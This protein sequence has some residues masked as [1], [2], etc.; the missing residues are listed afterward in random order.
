MQVKQVML[1]NP[2]TLYYWQT[3]SEAV[4]LYRRQEVNCAPVL[5]ADGE[6]VGIITVFRLL[7]ALQEGATM[8]TPIEEVMERKLVC[9]DEETGFEQVAN[10]PID[11]LI[12]LNKERRLSGVL[13]RIGL[14]N[15]VH[16]ALEKTERELAAVL[17]A[18]PNGIIAVDRE[19]KICHI[20]PAAARLLD[21]P[22][23]AV[24][25][26]PAETV[27]AASGLNRFLNQTVGDR[28][29][30]AR[31]GPKTLAIRRSPIT[32]DGREQGMVLV[33]QD[34]SELEAVSSELKAVK[35]L[36]RQLKSVIEAC[37]DGMVIVDGQGLVLGV[38]EAYGRIMGPEEGA[39]VVG[40][41]LRGEADRAE[42]QLYQLW[43]LVHS[44]GK[45]VTVMYQTPAGRE[46][47]L[48]GSP[49][50]NEEGGVSQVVIT[51]RD[52]TELRHLKEEAQRAAAEIRALRAQNLAASG[53]VC[54]SPN[55]QKVLEQ[56]LR[57]A[58]VDSTVL[59]TG[60][61]GV[62]KEVL[63]R[64][65][66]QHSHRSKGPFIEINCGAIPE[67]LLES[68]LFGYEKGAFTGANREGKLGLL[69]VANNGTI[70]LDE[71]GDLPLGLQVK[72]LRFLQEQVIYRLGGRQAV[73][74]NVRVI[75]AT[76]K[77]LAAMVKE[78]TFREDLY[79]RLNVVPIR[80]PPL[81]ERREDI[82][83]LA[84]YFLERF[85]Q[86]Y[87]TTKQLSFKACRVLEAYSWPGN[88][89]E[90]QNVMERVVIMGEGDAI[91][92]EHLPIDCREGNDCIEK[93]LQIKEILPLQQAREML[94]RELINLAVQ[95][96]GTLRR[97]AR[98]LGISHSTLLRKAQAYGLLVQ[99]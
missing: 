49:V 82:L 29:H 21:L 67:N 43:K 18:V 88:V 47:I 38:N 62:G 87:G 98:A 1:D 4:D 16:R 6:V 36:N 61:S 34:I 57:V 70:F 80:I 69:E 95:E 72:L 7:E 3:L 51:V 59:I 25:K 92:P 75:A 30:K 79:Y 37:Y 65:I 22:A 64:F 86:K 58:A 96:H 10:L 78:K 9:I 85:N 83:P 84:K 48:T 13:T 52:M 27:L 99:K 68:E 17:E 54:E 66:H 45:A 77:D 24:L 74:L 23:G 14:I 15:K 97:A 55:M 73:K 35:S 5:D 56:A 71:I 33:L 12:V 11:R 90:L 2:E 20:N 32:R 53:L 89:R 91:L 81:R 28:F 26:R 42:G 76:N 8:S 39:L 60:E 41:K 94:E 40:E 19:G 44:G 50:F 93:G 31:V 46:A 63:A